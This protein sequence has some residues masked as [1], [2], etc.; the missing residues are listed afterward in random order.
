VFQSSGSALSPTA[1]NSHSPV[2]GSLA[3]LITWS[4]SRSMPKAAW[5]SSTLS[6]TTSV[7][8][9]AV[10]SQATPVLG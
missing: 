4:L 3:T 10:R 9:A 2:V 6:A 5:R 7:R 1:L 8:L